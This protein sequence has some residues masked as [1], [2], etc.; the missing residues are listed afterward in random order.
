LSAEPADDAVAA[1]VGDAQVTVG[2]VKREMMS[3][4]GRGTISEKALP[5]WQAKTLDLLVDRQVVL[6][7]LQRQE[8]VVKPE[9]IDAAL[10]QV[11]QRLQEQKLTWEEFL[12]KQ[13]T[14]ETAMRNQIRWQMS[15]NRYAAREL[16]DDVLTDLFKSQQAEYDGRKIR[17]SHIVL[18]PAGPGGE[19][20]IKRLVQ[21]AMELKGRIER[22]EVTFADAAKQYSDG[23][24]R[25]EGGDLGLI[26]R[27]G[28]MVEPF[29]KAAFTLQPGQISNP[30]V[31]PFGIHL[32]QATAIDGGSKTA[33]DNRDELR[34]AA[35][36][37]L[38]QRI[39]AQE[40]RT[41]ELSFTGVL[42]YS[43]PETRALVMPK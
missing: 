2:D 5:L 35:A 31:T 11:K 20:E 10:A 30:V 32:I 19:A 17:V 1:K 39:A 7:L 40:R 4:E 38:F 28:E 14:T 12:A 43:D 27:H 24:S 22:K 8:Q 15:W 21:L 9:E 25:S 26:S 16:T 33:D 41:A 36:L 3:L 42:P 29:S 13:K 6:A 18:R 23:P 34:K 37:L